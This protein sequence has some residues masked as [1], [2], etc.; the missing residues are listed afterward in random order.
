MSTAL[1]ARASGPDAG[2]AS[3]SRLLLV[4]WMVAGVQS[5]FEQMRSS[6]GMEQARVIPVRPFREGGLI[7]RLPLPPPLRGTIRSTVAAA[8]SIPQRGIRAVWTQV[9][10][11]ML[12]FAMTRSVPIHYAIDCTPALLHGFGNQYAGVD[13]PA[14]PAGRLVGA[15]LRLYFSRCAGLLPWSAWAARSMIRDYAAAADRVHVVPPGI[16][17]ERW[18]PVAHEPPARPRLLFVGG[19]F[20]RKGGPLLLDAYRRH[21]RDECDLHLVTRARLAPEPGVFVYNGLEVGDAGLRELYQSSD[22]L[23]LPT[24]ADCFSMAA[25]EAMACGLPVV[26]SG[27][28]GISEIVTDGETGMLITP[29]RGDSLLRALR[30]M[31]AAP[32]LRQRFGLAGRRRVE[33]HF[34][35]RVQSAATLAIM[36]GSGA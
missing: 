5:Q 21:L 33:Q 22:L 10:L 4:P 16:D 19:D 17:L 6:P 3:R 15:C 26:I 13:D 34:D 31:L 14:S 9:A 24:T 30:L 23:V 18:F 7:E 36:A 29:G 1:H 20:Q 27:V 25:L 35:A 28:G 32:G 11:P 8:A 2:L 12:P